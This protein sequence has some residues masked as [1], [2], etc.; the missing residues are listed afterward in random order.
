MTKSMRSIL[1]SLVIFIM[2]FVFSACPSPVEVDKQLIAPLFSIPSGTYNTAAV[3]SIS[4]Q[5]GATIRYTIDGSIPTASTGTVYTTPVTITATATLTAVAFQSGWTASPAT[6][7][8]FE[9][10][11]DAVPA[12]LFSLPGG[13]YFSERTVGISASP[14]STIRYTLNGST[15]TATTGT[16]YSR[17]EERRGG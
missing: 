14:G 3:V 17:S 16:A 1:S 2:A 5:A 15:P 10:N 4:A 6:E 9:I 12:P 11:Q 13:V 7:A 8:L